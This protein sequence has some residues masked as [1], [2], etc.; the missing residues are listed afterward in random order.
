MDYKLLFEERQ[1]PIFEV[2]TQFISISQQ[3]KKDR[4][5]TRSRH[6][7]KL[8]FYRTLPWG[9]VHGACEG[10]ES[11]CGIGG[12][13]YFS[14]DHFISLKETLSSGTNNREK[15][16][17]LK[18]LMKSSLSRRIQK[19]KVFEDSLLVY[20]MDEEAT[21]LLENNLKFDQIT[22]SRI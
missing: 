7:G 10:E 17:A 2:T 21:Q 1:I 15:C 8:V 22:F 16:M 4:P 13:L 19:L 14:D 3:L 5:I 11:I 18:A 12:I 20:H 6:I 9:F